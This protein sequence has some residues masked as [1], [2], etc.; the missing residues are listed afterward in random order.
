MATDDYTAEERAVMATDPKFRAY[1]RKLTG[2]QSPSYSEILTALRATGLSAKEAAQYALFATEN[3]GD[4]MFEEEWVQLGARQVAA[5]EIYVTDPAHREGIIRVERAPN[6]RGGGYLIFDT[7]N[8]AYVWDTV[9][10]AANSADDDVEFLKRSGD[11]EASRMARE[12]REALTRVS[13]RLTRIRWG[14]R[15]L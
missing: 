6:M 12:D 11:Q 10:D 1:L 8:I 13:A 14:T 9:N 3:F 5:L 2:K 4:D 7:P 15:T